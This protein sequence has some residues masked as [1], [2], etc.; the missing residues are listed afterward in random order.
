MLFE[1]L[2]VVL[3]I[4]VASGWMQWRSGFETGVVSALAYLDREGI[5]EI[6]PEDE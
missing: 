2:I 1:L 5:I 4:L 6:T 3:V